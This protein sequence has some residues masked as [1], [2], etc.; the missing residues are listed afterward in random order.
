MTTSRH[1]P[2]SASVVV[3]GGG[4]VGLSSAYHLARHGVRDVVLL[5]RGTLGSGST[6]KAAGGVRAQFSDPVNIALGARSLETFRDFPRLFGQEIDFA[7]VGYLFLLGTPGSVAAFE[8]NV[9]LQ[10]DLGV[11]SR[12]IDVD[13]ARRLSPLVSPEGLLAAAYSPTDGHCTP[14]SVVAGYA[15]AARRAGA[16]LLPHCAATSID[17]RDGRIDGVRTEGGTIRTDT[18]VCAAGAWSAEVGSW[19]GVDL[20]VT[21]L[22][23]QI[24]VTEPVAGLDPHTPFTIDFETSFYFHREGE[25][26]LLGL[27]DPDE[28]PGFEQARSDG[29]LPRLGAAIERRTPALAEVGIASG[30]AGLYEMSPDHNA[31]IGR[32]DTVEGF[33]YATGFSGHGFLMGPAVG[34][35]VRDLY[36][37][38]E[39]FVDVSGLGAARF[40]RA[41]ARPEL[42]I[43]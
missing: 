19:A 42:N 32:A 16:T 1:L 37:G 21:P 8:A 24:L 29:W 6:C 41:D 33:L 27:S 30:W 26:L 9:A 10:N 4:V 34:E 3:I 31:L 7:Q 35:V 17:V 12:M 5:D 15:S 22:R 14:E 40:A 38:D 43:V 2:S 39:P 18:V 11:P 28:V 23:R 13:E 20:P 36:I 25:G